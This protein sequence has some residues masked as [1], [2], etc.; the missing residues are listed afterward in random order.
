LKGSDHGNNE[1]PGYD[2]QETRDD[3][4]KDG[5]SND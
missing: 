2:S 4:H 3:T 1:D 5:C